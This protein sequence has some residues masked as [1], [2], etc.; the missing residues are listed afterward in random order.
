MKRTLTLTFLIVLIMLNACRQTSTQEQLQGVWQLRSM[1]IINRAEADNDYRFMI[2]EANM[3]GLYFGMNG[4]MFRNNKDLVFIRDGFNL[5]EDYKLGY[6]LLGRDGRLNEN[7]RTIEVLLLQSPVEFE[8]LSEPP[9]PFEIL[10]LSADELILKD[11]NPYTVD[12]TKN[13]MALRF[14]RVE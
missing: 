1:D 7:G 9:G 11:L 5:Y 10:S 4:L 13:N 8:G 6:R 14:S 12:I 3:M 2:E